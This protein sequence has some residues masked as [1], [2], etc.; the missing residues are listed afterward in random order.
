MQDKEVAET[1]QLC[2]LGGAWFS[3]EDFIRFVNTNILKLFSLSQGWEICDTKGRDC[4]E[5][6]SA[7][8]F[9]CSTTCVGIYANIQWVAFNDN[10]EINN[11]KTGETVEGDFKKK[12]EIASVD[13]EQRLANLE[14]EVKALKSSSIG[15]KGEKLDWK[16]YKQLVAEYRKFK[17]NSVKH[18]WFSSNASANT[19]GE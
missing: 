9:N 17:T 4:I 2:P 18:F 7:E 13:M 12:F 15:E 5:E 1:L 19:F 10:E 8:T 14:K 3:G 6:N 11:V 16:K